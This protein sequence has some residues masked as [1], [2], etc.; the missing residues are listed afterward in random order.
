MKIR[1]E[2][3]VIDCRGTPREMGRQW[4]AA[5]GSNLR[6]SWAI[7]LAILGGGYQATAE[8]VTRAAAEYLP[9]VREF[10]PQLVDM[11]EGLAEGAELAFEQVFALRCMFELGIH[12]GRLASLSR[13][14]SF[15]ATGEATRGGLTLLGQNIDWYPDFP[16][17]L[18]RFHYPNG[19]TQL[20]LSLGGMVEYTLSSAGFGICANSTLTPPE[21]FELH[22]PLG[23][24][25][26]R[27]MRARRISDALGLLCQAARG[28]GYYHLA[29]TDGE[30]VGI[31]SIFDD[32][33]I[34][35]PE[36]DLLLHTNHYLTERFQKGDLAWMAMPDSYLRITRIRRLLESRYGELTPQGM[37][38]ILADHRGHPVSICRHL[39]TDEPPLFNA[40]SR[41]SYVMVPEEKVMWLAAGNPCEYEYLPYYLE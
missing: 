34:L 39:A 31:E 15:A 21:K 25:L 17:D 28:V 33:Q 6:T 27:V 16:L 29:G 20:A 40:V 35:P 2:L 38:E 9:N 26:P 22:L 30:M 23:C 24:Y 18:L 3:P 11:L 10:D 5:C 12:Y 4:G 14:T 19:I 8:Q 1:K 41:A 13:C 7:N 36:G 37:M 32:F